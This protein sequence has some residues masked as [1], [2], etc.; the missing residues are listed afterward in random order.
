[1]QPMS[2]S[3]RFLSA[4]VL[5]LLCACADAPRPETTPPE[6]PLFSSRYRRQWQGSDLRLTFAASEPG[7]CVSLGETC[8]LSNLTSGAE[9]TDKRCGVSTRADREF[10]YVRFHCLERDPELTECKDSFGEEGIIGSIALAQEPKSTESEWSGAAPEGEEKSL[11]R[12]EKMG[13]E[14]CTDL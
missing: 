6:F 5:G 9:L 8:T 10:Y 3:G 13:L 4:V 12:V 1:M 7:W 11:S 14:S 2:Q